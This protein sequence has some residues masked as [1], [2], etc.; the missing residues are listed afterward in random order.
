M[1]DVSKLLAEEAAAA[2]AA[3]H[4]ETPMVR[5][6]V[7]AKEPSQVYS[8]RI[9]MARL[10]E[11]RQRAEQQHVAPTVLMRRW[12][13]D[14][15]D[16][17]AEQGSRLEERRAAIKEERGEEGLVVLTQSELMAVMASVLGK[18]A[19]ALTDDTQQTEP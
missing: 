11:L 15:L 3:A 4:V 10:E 1:T 5:N 12:I 16:E 2:E 17:E 9:P 13:L 6:R 7:K 14:R 18:L 19:T 8:L